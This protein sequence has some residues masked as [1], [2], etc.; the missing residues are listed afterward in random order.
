MKTILLGDYWRL[1]ED[2]ETG[3]P[4]IPSQPISFKQAKELFK[5]VQ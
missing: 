4:K 2:K 1:S 5:L 3:L